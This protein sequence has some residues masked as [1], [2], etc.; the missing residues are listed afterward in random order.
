M[1]NCINARGLL[2]LN[3]WAEKY[4]STWNPWALRPENTDQLWLDW[5][6]QQGMSSWWSCF[7]LREIAGNDYQDKS[8]TRTIC[9]RKMSWQKGCVHI[10]QNLLWTSSSM[11][12]PRL[13]KGFLP[14]CSSSKVE[15]WSL[16]GYWLCLLLS[17]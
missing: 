16:Q 11:S 7:L 2:R 5:M 17:V 14:S 15:E 1:Y 9:S 8:K 3:I 4:Q 12:F 6:T 10:A 13:M